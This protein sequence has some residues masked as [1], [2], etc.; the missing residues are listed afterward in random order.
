VA[1]DAEKAS[2]YAT[3]ALDLLSTLAS[4]HHSIFQAGEAV[5][6]LSDALRDKRPEIAT[7]AARVLGKINSQDGERALAQAALNTEGDPALRVVFM[8]G[9]AESA[10]RTGNALDAPAINSLIKVV[11][12]PDTD[13]KL[14][15]AAATALGALNVPSNQA[16][17]L[18][19]QQA[20]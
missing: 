9:L 15:N 8:D 10:K 14:R 13:P 6:A 11:S 1:V 5:P 17:T 12:A 3:T 20:K 19:L 18:I 2:Q 7:G 4:D 16:S